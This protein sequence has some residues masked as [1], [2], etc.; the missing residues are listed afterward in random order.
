MG[1]LRNSPLLTDLY[2]FTMLQGYLRKGMRG[3]AAFE[4]FVR[5]LP[6]ERNFLVAAGLDTLLDYLE[7]VRFTDDD[8][9]SL[10]KA[11]NFSQELLDYLAGFRFRGDVFAVAEGM[12]VFE[13]EPIVRVE[14]DIKEGQLVETRL[15]NLVHFQT[16]IA[17]KAARCM[18][19]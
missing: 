9:S 15:I 14:A 1:D 8:L 2:Q 18:L 16:L 19:A 17:S 3:R 10:S 11:G 12:P 7:A 13:N 5:K 6:P 4:F